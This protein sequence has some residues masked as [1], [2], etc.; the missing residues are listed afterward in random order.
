M[1][2][3][4]SI[5][6][7]LVDG[8]PGGLTTVEMGNWTGHL[9]S[10]ARQDLAT[11]LK[12][13]EVTRTGIYLLLGEDPAT[14]GRAMVYVGESET[15]SDRLLEHN[16]KKD[17]WNRAVLVT[18]KDSNITKAHAKY[19]EWRLIV[20]A[21][22]ANRVTLDNT[23]TPSVV[24]LP[25]SDSSDMEFFIDQLRIALPVL[26]ID[27]LRSTHVNAGTPGSGASPVFRLKT[28]DTDATAQEID[29]EFIVRADSLAHPTWDGSGTSYEKL[30]K[31]LEVDGTLVP[32][33]DG[34]HLIFTRDHVFRSPS[35]ASAVVLGRN[36]NG[37]V[38]WKTEDGSQTYAQ[39]Q[40][41]A[42]VP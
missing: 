31:A 38:E 41:P 42:V 40:E 19:L 9:L 18:S 26:G 6:V 14:P 7:F 20:L 13:D 5:R 24:G 1:S 37:R 32:S 2:R 11:L 29:D 25:E 3:G 39:W 12:R 8:T 23:V 28:R 10:A 35:A 27:L 21:R 22:Q 33:K 4:K 30:R 17:F 34:K 36:S 15:V 16:K